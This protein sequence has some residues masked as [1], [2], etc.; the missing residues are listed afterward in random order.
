VIDDLDER[1]SRIHPSLMEKTMTDQTAARDRA[2]AKTR[3]LAKSYRGAKSTQDIADALEG[4]LA[5]LDR[6]REQATWW[7]DAGLAAHWEW[8]RYSTAREP[9]TAAGALV[10]LNNAMSDL[11][12]YLPGY[13]AETGTIRGDDDE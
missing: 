7:H 9:I 11:A 12:S 8:E 6:L 3:Q 4:T 10:E 5:E 1:Y 13:D 2:I